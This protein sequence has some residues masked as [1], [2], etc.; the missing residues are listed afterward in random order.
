MCACVQCLRRSEESL[1]A[2]KFLPAW[3]IEH[4]NIWEEEMSIEELLLSD[5]PVSKSVDVSLVIDVGRAIL[6]DDPGLY[7][8]A[9]WESLYRASQKT[10]WFLL[11]FLHAGCLF[12][13][14]SLTPF[15]DELSA[16]SWNKPFP[17]TVAFWAWCF[18]PAWNRKQTRTVSDPLELELQEVQNYPKCVVGAELGSS[19]RTA[20]SHNHRAF[21]PAPQLYL[22]FCLFVCL[23]SQDLMLLRLDWNSC[24]YLPNAETTNLPPCPVHNGS[25]PQRWDIPGCSFYSHLFAVA[26]SCCISPTGLELTL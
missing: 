7:N 18:I 5:W 2:S 21:P 6:L 15:H 1:A 9:G 22:Y 17:P 19:E 24:L 13:V 20:R 16:E 4:R 10:A 26:E 23:F 12:W 3:P 8:K 25:F 14:P 11:Q